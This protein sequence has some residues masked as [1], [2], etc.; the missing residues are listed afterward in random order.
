MWSQLQ[1][2]ACT[3]LIALM[4]VACKPTPSPKMCVATRN[5]DGSISGIAIDSKARLQ[6]RHPANAIYDS[7]CSYIK[8][9]TADFIWYEGRLVPAFEYRPRLSGQKIKEVDL[10]ISVGAP[11]EAGEMS[12]WQY[13]S[14][15]P[16][17]K[18]PLILYPKYSWKST[19]AP[20]RIDPAHT[21][22][23]AKTRNP[24]TG[25]PY[26]TTC[27]IATPNP[28]DLTSVVAGDIDRT[29]ADPKCRGGISVERGSVSL[30]ALIDVRGEGVQDI[31]DIY[32]AA[33][34]ELESYI[35]E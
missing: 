31:G 26:T 34:K 2:L 21:W 25:Q 3:A 18:F 24:R 8:S 28:A 30:N 11:R 14:P 16:H 32:L 5:A 9:I 19:S 22:G 6:L 7:S 27:N 33:I 12:P 29:M 35:E 20:G 13:D 4:A 23:V 15:I 10:S 1:R 17:T